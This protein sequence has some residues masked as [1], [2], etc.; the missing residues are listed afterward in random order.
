MSPDTEYSEFWNSIKENTFT[1][2]ET[3]GDIY[4]KLEEMCSEDK[5][6]NYCIIDS[7]Q[8]ND[9]DNV[10][11]LYHKL[12]GNRIKYESSDNEF[13]TLYNYPIK[14]CNYLKY[15]LY[16]KIIFNKFD[17]S[18]ITKVLEGL[19]KGDKI[20]LV[21]GNSYMCI[22]DILKLEKIKM[23]KLFYD[24]LGNYDVAQKKSSI[25]D[26]I[27]G[28]SYKEILNKMIDLYNDKK[29][30]KESYEYSNEFRECKNTYNIDSVCKLQCLDDVSL[31]LDKEQER[32][33]EVYSLSQHSSQSGN[34]A[35][36]LSKDPYHVREKNTSLGIITTVIPTLAV[37]FVIFPILYKL[38]SF[39][40]WL[41]KSVMKTKNSLFNPNE[42][43][44]DALLNHISESGSENFIERP[45][46]IAYHSY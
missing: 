5:N 27:C 45:H 36:K 41:H 28:S 30:E 10:K 44:T 25:N 21:M 4:T 8:Y 17:E 3:L 24:Y 38:T 46:Y 34:P 29:G 1:K 43:S 32:C 40:P 31:S 2:N 33:S 6:K 12:Y 22:F 11:K 9:C 35:A 20:Q 13:T 39:G 14:F 42:N 19:E 26:K 37:S 16:D 23:I 15:W 7:D 18:E